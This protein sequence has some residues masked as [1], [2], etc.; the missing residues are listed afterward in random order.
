MAR[1]V[2]KTFLLTGSVNQKLQK[3]AS[4]NAN[5]SVTDTAVESGV[6][7]DG[8]AHVFYDGMHISKDSGCE[9]GHRHNMWF[10]NGRDT[11]E[12]YTVKPGSRCS[13]IG[14]LTT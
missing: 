11:G 1:I 14:F 8:T 3:K 10:S 9:I 7:E 13:P 2:P 6:A 12:K 5:A 4:S